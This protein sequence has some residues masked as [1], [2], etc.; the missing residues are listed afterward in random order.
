MSIAEELFFQGAR[1]A[2]ASVAPGLFTGFPGN[3]FALALGGTWPGAEAHVGL[4]PTASSAA[5]VSSDADGGNDLFG[6]P[7]PPEAGQAMLIVLMAFGLMCLT[8]L[9]GNELELPARYRAWRS[10]WARRL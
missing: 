4:A 10:R 6:L 7:I 8:L 1:A 9:F 2:A 5:D 3:G